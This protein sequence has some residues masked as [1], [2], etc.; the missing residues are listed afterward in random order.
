MEEG[1]GEGEGGGGLDSPKSRV[2]KSLAQKAKMPLML[3][4]ISCTLHVIY[5]LPKEPMVGGTV[6]SWLVCPSPDQAVRVQALA[7]DTVLCS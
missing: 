3:K 5:I 2:A 7:G 1:G 4:T 6:A